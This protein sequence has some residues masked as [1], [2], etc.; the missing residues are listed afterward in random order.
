[1][2]EDDGF[3]EPLGFPIMLSVVVAG[4]SPLEVLFVGLYVPLLMVMTVVLMVGDSRL[5]EIVEP[6]ETTYIVGV[7]DTVDVKVLQLVEK[8]DSGWLKVVLIY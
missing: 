2:T 7:I 8:G 6:L 5:V 3:P 1:M 4:T